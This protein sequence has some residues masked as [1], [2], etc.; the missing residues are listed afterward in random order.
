MR[1]RTVELPGLLVVE[2]RVHRDPRGWFLEIWREET[3]AADPLGG[4]GLSGPWVQDNLSRSSR[5]VLRGL[6]FQW[7]LPQAKL[8][9]A[10]YGE[11]FDVAVDVRRDSPTFG[12]WFGIRLTAEAGNQLFIPAGF[13]HGFCTLSD[14]A[15]LLYKCSTPYRPAGDR[16]LLWND[17][18]V[19]IDW[20]TGE[21]LLSDKDARGRLLSDFAVDE[22]PP[23]A[24]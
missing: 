1:V 10:A 18:A 8:V 4:T 22:L 9:S 6:H 23:F 19:G 5:N 17:P 24:A 7:P 20:P 11:I 15:V 14:E 16:S 21:P 2:P 13:A 12:K 3:A